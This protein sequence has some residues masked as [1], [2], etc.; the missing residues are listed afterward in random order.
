MARKMLVSDLIASLAARKIVVGFVKKMKFDRIL[1][2]SY[3]GVE[4]TL[5]GHNVNVRAHNHV[6]IEVSMARTKL[7]AI[8]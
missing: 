4:Y 6:S 2:E 5:M 8:Y 1:I 3:D 7:L